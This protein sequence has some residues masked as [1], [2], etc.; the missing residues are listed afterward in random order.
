[1]DQ[2]PAKCT[3]PKCQFIFPSPFVHDTSGF[4]LS[5]NNKIQ[6]PKCD[7]LA[8][9][10]DVVGHPGNILYPLNQRSKDLLNQVETIL[11]QF[12]AGEVSREQAVEAANVLSPKAAKAVSWAIDMDQVNALLAL[13]GILLTILF[14]F[15]GD[16]DHEEIMTEMKK[17]N[18]Y[19]ELQLEQQREAN[20]LIAE[21][22][23]E[24]Q[25]QRKEK[26]TSDRKHGASKKRKF[27]PRPRT[28]RPVDRP[29][30][31]EQRR[32]R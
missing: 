10:A 7:G 24:T 32:P 27:R 5:Q 3:N 20:D 1:L 29:R 11:R 26:A 22:L 8:L 18:T 15:D 30:R 31:P 19:A 17:S 9:T 13:L 12:Q 28:A 4:F 23:R 14:K 25:L 2:L 16:V 21:V 6:C